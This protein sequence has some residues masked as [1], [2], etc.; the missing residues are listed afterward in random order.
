[1]FYTINLAQ[2]KSNIN[3]YL[4]NTL[5]NK[6]KETLDNNSKVI[7]YL[8]KRW[9]FSAL[10]CTKC[11]YLFKC[12]NCDTSLS[13]HR[14]PR[15]LL[16]HICS[17]EKEIKT[18]CEKCNKDWLEMIWVWTEQIE[19]KIRNIFNDKN[20]YRFDTDSVKNN[21]LKSD[22][23]N[24]LDK[25]D[26]II[27]TKMITTWFDFN[28]IWLI[29]IILLEQ[30]LS[31][32]KYNT[33]EKVYLNIKQLIW[34]WERLWNKTD[35]IIQTFIPENDI[36]QTITDSNYKFFFLKTLKDRK[37]FNYPPYTEMVT[38]EYRNKNKEQ[39]INFMVNLKN[40]L[41]LNN[42]NNK[43]TINLVPDTQ[44]RYNQYFK[45]IIIRWEN[46]RLF[47]ENIKIEIMKNSNLVIV[48]E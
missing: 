5:I 32:P 31:I 29:W 22:S 47:I 2:D 14:N 44:K 11:N 35:F 38:L 45:K 36:I 12:P 10:I 20:I 37:L 1:M 33:E 19:E 43:Y 48:F 40:K 39:S 42:L 9:N 16:C 26:I 8:N 25:A 4:S 13:V 46:I 27:W 7:L 28:N 24:K 30:E 21:K 17:Y 15:K 23:L 34:R 3:H 18:N 41:D 6:I